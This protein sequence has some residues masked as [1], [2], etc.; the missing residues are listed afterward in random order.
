MTKLSI[1]LFFLTAATAAYAQQWE[2]GGGGGGSFL[3][4]VSVTSPKG[5]ATTGFQ[6]GFAA[7]VYVGQN[8][9]KHLSGEIR[10]TFMQSDLKLASGGTTATFSGNTHA[11]Y[12][13]FLIHTNRRESRAQLYGAVG[14]GMKIFRGTGKE[15]A[16]QPLSDF[17]YFT[18]TQAVKP[19]L[20]VG[21]GAKFKLSPHVSLRTE[22]RDFVT[23]F[24]KDLIAPAP[25]AKFGRL[26]HDFVP[27]VS[28]GYEY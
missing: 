4:G 15:A 16:Y 7:G 21:G 14:G 11:V 20:S 3:P 10:Y 23:P 22:V 5:A 1:S 9:Y 12:Y 27:M 2:I 28:I 18:K 8:L 19:M 13:D 26:L 24:P 17:G 25:G 6:P